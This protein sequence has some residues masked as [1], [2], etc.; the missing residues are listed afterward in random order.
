MMAKI[1]MI[2]HIAKGK[3]AFDGQTV[4]SRLV[5]DGLKNYLNIYLVDTYSKRKRLLPIFFKSLKCLFCC[6][7][8]VIMLSRNGLKVFLPLLFLANKILKTKVYHC[9][10]GGNDFELLQKKPKWIKYMNSFEVNWYESPSLANLL[11]KKGLNNARYLPNFKDLKPLSLDEL[12]LCT[13]SLSTKRE[14]SFCTFSRVTKEK[15]ITLAIESLSKIIKEHNY[16][17]LLDIYGPID[18]GY[19]DEF[20]TLLEKYNFVHYKGVI[21]P[22]KSV[23]TLKTYYSLLFPTFFYGEGFPGTL[24]DSMCSGVPVIASDWHM[25]PEIISHLYDGLIFGKTTD[26][27]LEEAIIWAI[28]NKTEFLGFKE[29]TWRQSRKYLMARNIK[30][31]NSF[32]EAKK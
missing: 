2:A 9:V 19:K 24:I 20:D 22:N 4:K 32:M 17:V 14:Y 18:S 15:G 26:I 25:N 27:S 16:N 1:G 29:R 5:Y 28:E 11:R 13:A 10:I 31:I 21:A 30:I 3:D 7:K 23:E 6:K 8:V 12:K